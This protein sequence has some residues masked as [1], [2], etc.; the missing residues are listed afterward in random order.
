MTAG[1]SVWTV[2]VLLQTWCD[3]LLGAVGGAI[4]TIAG[5]WFD[6]VARA[7]AFYIFRG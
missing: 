7:I 3:R 2:G 4:L 6:L 5:L 1:A